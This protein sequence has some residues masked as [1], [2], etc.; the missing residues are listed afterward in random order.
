MT[1]IV[2]RDAMPGD[3]GRIAELYAPFV[4]ETAISFEEVPPDEAEFRDRISAAQEH[5]AWLV[6]ETD[7]AFRGYAYAPRFRGRAAYD[8]TCET[9][10]YLDAAVRGRGLGHALGGAL[11]ERVET[12]GYRSAI[13]GVA[14]PNAPS[15]ALHERLGYRPVGTVERAGWKFGRWHAI[16]FWERPL[17]ASPGGRRPGRS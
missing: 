12:L 1:E 13:A 17:G 15:Q 2:I 5:H 4:N 6:L 9:A 7:G 10:I 8:W 16:E 14:L 3:A 11:L